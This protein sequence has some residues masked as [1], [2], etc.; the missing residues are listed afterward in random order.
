M[1]CGLAIVIGSITSATPSMADATAGTITGQVVDQQNEPIAHASI[2][3]ADTTTS[4]IRTTSTNEVGRYTILDIP[5]GVYDVT[6]T[7]TGF[8]ASRLSGQKVEVGEVLTLD[9]TLQVGATATTV[10]VKATAGAVL[11]TL[12]ATVGSTITNESLQL[13]PNLGRDASALSVMQVG[14]APTGNVAGASTDQ[15]SFT[16]DGGYNSDDMAGNNTSYVPGNGYI[17]T[18][19]SG[20]TPSGVIPAP[21]ESIEEI[22]IGT[23]GQT[24]DFNS[25]GG[26]QVQMVTKR[27]TNQFHGALYEFYFG[28]NVGAANLWKNNHTPDPAL[29]LS[30]TPLPA[31]HR[32][33]YGGAIGGPMTPKFWGGKTYFFANYEAM[34]YPNGTSFE[35]AVP[36]AA[37][38]L[39]LVELPNS[40]N[41]ETF[42]NLNPYNVVYNGVTY[43]PSQCTFNGASGPCDPRN[44]GMNAV[45]GQLWSKLPLPNDPSYIV[46]GASDG[47]NEQGYLGVLSLPQTSNFFVA[48]IDHDFG[49][50]WKFMSSYRYYAYSQATNNQTTLSPN[51]A[52][53]STA[54]RPQKPD[55]LIGALTTALTPNLT[56]DLRV[57]YLRN[58]WQWADAGGPPNLPGLGGAIEPGGESAATNALLPT[59]V[60]SQNTRQRFW[61]GHDQW[62]S[63]TLSLLNGDHLFQFGGSYLRAFDYHERNDNGVGIDAYPTYQLTNGSGIAANGYPIPAGLASSQA[64]SYAQLYSEVLGIVGQ[65]QVMYSRSGQNLTLNPVGTP[66]FAQS[67]IAT[68]DLF[69]SDTWHARPNLTVTYGLAW[70][71]GLPP[72]EINGKQVVLVD[73]AGNPIN[74]ANF[75]ASRETAALNGQGYAP[76]VGFATVRNVGSGE[77]YPFSPFY[78]GFS[79]RISVA[80]NPSFDWGI[81]GSVF[82]RNKTVLRAGYSRIYARANGIEL[83]G[84]PL[85]GPGILQAVS[86]YP[87]M[88]GTCANA[89]TLSAANAFRI[90]TD[91]LTSPLPPVTQTLSQPYFAGVNGNAQAS[92]GL[93]LD[94]NYKAN[95][96]DEINITIQRSFSTKALVEVGYLGKKITNMIQ[97]I[98][99]DAVPTMMTLNGQTFANAYGQIFSEYCGLSAPT[100]ENNPARVTAQPFFEAALGGKNSPFCATYASCT[101][102][103]VANFS[104]SIKATQVYTLWGQLSNANGWALGRTLLSSPALGTGI[105][106]QITAM[107]LDT[108]LGHGSYNAGFVKFTTRDWHG[109]TASS[110]FTYSKGLGT[111]SLVSSSS[112]STVPDPYDL[113]VGYGPWAFDYKF[114]YSLLTLYQLPFFRGQQ[115]IVGHILGGW[116]IAPILTAQSGAPLQISNDTGSNQNAQAFGEVYGNGNAAFYENAVGISP[117]TGGNS[118]HSGVA[119]VG[120]VATS[121]TTA[122]NLFANPLQVYNEFRP[123]VLGLDTNMNGAGPIRGF[124]TWNVDAALAKDF[125]P[126]ERIGAT[127]IIQFVNLFNHFQPASPS[128]NIDAPQSWGVV[129]NQATTPNGAQSR[130]MEFG[131]RLRF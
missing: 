112:S 107:E 80:W 62:Y 78:G 122:L 99:I 47:F 10:E 123:P 91:G 126:T 42:Y 25:A 121:G 52:Y 1:W 96:S 84:V 32:N 77:K 48:R 33:R 119:G 128:M 41:V 14:V 21:I 15:N 97:Q 46:S 54:P 16:L 116:S 43:A 98:N 111:A 57:S 69:W 20:G 118:L 5:P 55:F 58:W 59:N 110:N 71:L 120:G 75:L 72:Y 108:S 4:S 101:A 49:D 85:V 115:G 40:A 106:P 68:Y 103:V 3:L 63:D 26:S 74:M 34:R 6:V 50:K 94:P 130:W 76:E 82:S 125:N 83:V 66:G 13:L 29:G 12:N 102:A 73:Q 105:N 100:C 45:V 30:Y 19:S 117:F 87:S 28:N 9:V 51:G 44:I 36:T 11:Q 113:R 64:T 39:G 131:L 93:L 70:S 38:R 86:C 37:L 8:T 2:I 23:S 89:G 60:N 79:P 35:R 114:V 18:A 24:P 17:G 129:T 104:G 90:G 61:D 92:D 127:L 22:K 56:N 7:K 88:N 81:L 67:I 109:V 53:T 95:H 31:T 27:G 124:P 65:S